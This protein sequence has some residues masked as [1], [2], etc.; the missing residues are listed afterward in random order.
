MSSDREVIVS[1]KPLAQD[2]GTVLIGQA[3][4]V[5][6]V[7]VTF[8][9]S[10]TIGSMAA[11][12]QGSAG[13]DFAISSVGTCQVGTYIGAG[14]SC[15]VNLT[16]TP[17]FA[18]LR[19][20]AVTIEDSGGNAIATGYVHGMGSGPQVS[21]LPGSQS[22]LHGGFALPQGVAVDGS[23]NLYVADSTN[24]AV[25]EVPAAGGYTSVKSLGGD[26][27]YP[28]G[29]AMDGSGNVFV[30]DAGNSTVKEIPP[31]CISYSCVKTLGGGTTFSGLLV[32]IAVD[33]S[34][35]VFVATSG[36]NGNIGNFGGVYEIPM[37]GGYTTVNQLV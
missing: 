19:N 31:G 22:T 25:Y 28:T 8:Q 23:G 14:N 13:L 20:G 6:P 26:F 33:R 27:S 30:A 1:Y 36:W 11:L 24:N 29:V 18:G 4:A 2:F 21:F 3:S 15:T 32:G 12:T 9:T 35:N 17:K 37:A 5:V 34:S 16:F 10:G 7:A